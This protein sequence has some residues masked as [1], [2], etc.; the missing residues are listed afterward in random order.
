MDSIK[1]KFGNI[2]ANDPTYFVADISANHDGDIGRAKDLIFLAAEAGANAAKFQNFK[3][4]TILSA[5]GFRDLKEKKSHQVAWD[6]PVFEVYQD[7]SLPDN[8][9]QKLK[10]WADEAGIDYFS[11]PYD[12]DFVED[13]NPY[14]ELFKIGS[15][16]ITWLE[17]IKKV[18][19]THKPIMLATGASDFEDVRRAVD[20]IRQYSNPLVLMQCNTNYTASHENFKYINLNVINTYRDCFPHSILGLSDHTQGHVTVLGA[21]AIGARVIE[22]HFTDDITRKG[23][24]H[25]FSMEPSHWRDM[26]CATRDLESAMGNGI[27]VIEE[28]ERETAVVQRRSLRVKNDLAAGTIITRE[29]LTVLRPAPANSLLPYELSNVLG[30]KL[31]RDFQAHEMLGAADI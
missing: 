1:T 26:V 8:W 2:S 19:Q 16:D 11:T 6:K 20:C 21:V 27:K 13:L 4:Q 17:I 15:G 14:V 25:P 12:L 30:K 10:A 23:P 9:A 31:K 3:A 24:D 7:A 28:N 29:D 18:C 22:K 5:E